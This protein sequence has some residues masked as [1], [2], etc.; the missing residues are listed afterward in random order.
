MTVRQFLS[1]AYAL[2]VESITQGVDMPAGI[3]RIEALLG[4]REAPAPVP[5][6]AAVAQNDQALR[7]L[8][9]MMG[10]RSRR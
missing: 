9:G 4:L 7:E 3:E 2:L 1:A 6:A 8:Q 5:A 10:G